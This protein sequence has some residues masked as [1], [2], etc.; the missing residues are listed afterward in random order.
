MWMAPSAEL[1]R[2]PAPATLTPKLLFVPEPPRPAS[3]MEPES[4]V[5]LPRTLMPMPMNCPVV[6]V[7]CWLACSVTSPLVVETLA[8]V[9][10]TMYLDVEADRSD[11]PK[12]DLPLKVIGPAVAA[13]RTTRNRSEERRVGEER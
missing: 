10:T 4:D 13:S 2:A 7:V 3:R 11:A 5:M 1:T 8:P 9:F 12:L 6:G